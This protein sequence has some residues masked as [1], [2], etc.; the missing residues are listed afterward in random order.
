MI[1]PQISNGMIINYFIKSNIIYCY[2]IL[3]FYASNFLPYFGSTGPFMI[4]ACAVD[5]LAIGI[6]NG[7]HDTTS[8]PIR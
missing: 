2:L 5:N 8:S 3:I 6:L 1:N 7:E 4:V